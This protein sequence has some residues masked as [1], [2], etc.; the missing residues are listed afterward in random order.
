MEF[1]NRYMMLI[2]Q[3]ASAEDIVRE[4][5]LAD[6][7][8]EITVVFGG[9][10][11]AK[12]A[13]DLR[14]EILIRLDNL[15]SDC[16]PL[17]RVEFIDY[18]GRCAV[19]TNPVLGRFSRAAVFHNKVALL[20]KKRVSALGKCVPKRVLPIGYALNV[21]KGGE[22]ASL[23]IPNIIDA[24]FLVPPLSTVEIFYSSEFSKWD[25]EIYTTELIS[26]LDNLIRNNQPIVRVEFFMKENRVTWRSHIFNEVNAAIHSHL[27]KAYKIAVDMGITSWGEGRFLMKKEEYLLET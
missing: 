2:C 22:D 26:Q 9:E 23:S 10:I 12:R 17:V 14:S 7:L 6:P 21:I 4:C 3:D 20:A 25:F 11:F 15:Q 1:Y 13:K 19:W 27:R 24:I 18:E 16:R 8:G 5:F